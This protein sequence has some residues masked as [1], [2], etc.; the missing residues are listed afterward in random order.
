MSRALKSESSL[1]LECGICCDGT[2][3]SNVRLKESDRPELLRALG[4]PVRQR[5]QL[6]RFSQP[7]AALCGTHCAV[8]KNRP[9][10]CR[11]FDCLVLTRLRKGELTREKALGL[12]RRARRLA[13]AADRG[14]RRLGETDGAAPVKL[15]FARMSKAMEASQDACSGKAARTFGEVS[16]TMHRLHLILSEEFFR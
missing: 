13:K 15:R 11:E 7:C 12:I 5:G 9:S 3:F 1:C 4:L 10:H 16:E 6:L 2:L 14:L 8:Y